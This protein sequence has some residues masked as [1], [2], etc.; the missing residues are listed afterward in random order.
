MH[1]PTLGEDMKKRSYSTQ[2]KSKTASTTTVIAS[3]PTPDRYDDVVAGGDEW[4][5][6]KYL[7]NPVVQFG[8]D[9]STPPVGKTEK[10][11]TDKDGNLVATIRWDDSP[12]NPLGQTVARQFREGFLSAVSVGFQPGRSTPRNKLPTDHPAYGASGMLF[13]QNQLLEISAVPVPANGEA[14]ALRGYGA[15][16]FK[17]ILSVEETDDS[18]IV[19]YAKHDEAMAEEEEPE[20]EIEEEAFGDEEEEE[21]LED[22]EEEQGVYG[23]EEE[24]AIGDEEEE[25]E[26]EEAKHMVKHALKALVQEV[27]IEVLGEADLEVLTAPTI[28]SAQSSCSHVDS[29]RTRQADPLGSVFGIDK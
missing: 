21:A 23:D 9:Y 16:Q 22:E 14:L 5:L 6:D 13:E 10:L 17:H 29:H 12:T 3:T 1:I 15:S 2:I 28:K 11:T 24:E 25:E 4:R 27:L 19:T 18:Y 8:H 26:D 7:A 20:D